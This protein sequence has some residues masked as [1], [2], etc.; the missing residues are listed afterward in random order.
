MPVTELEVLK[1]D[2][3]FL[4]IK[5]LNDDS[6]TKSFK[7]AVNAEISHGSGISI[8]ALATT[9]HPLEESTRIL[10]LDRDRITLQL[11][12]SRSVIRRDYPLESDLARLAEI[13]ELLISNTDLNGQTLEAVGVNLELVY[14]QDAR[15]PAVTYLAKRLLP[16]QRPFFQDWTLNGGSCKLHFSD[17][18]RRRWNISMEPRLNAPNTTK[19]FTNL[20]LHCDT[21]KLPK[22]QEVQQSFGEAWSTVIE[23]IRHVDGLA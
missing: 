5:L 9:G 21:D 1:V 18:E 17:K 19:V 15:L 14:D 20:N 11:S 7:E 16:T 22:R 8:D 2:L 13:V 10:S 23:F 3:V 12:S 4:G 6:R